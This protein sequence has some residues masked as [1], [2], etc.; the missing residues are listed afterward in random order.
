MAEN[1]SNSSTENKAPAK[2]NI[3]VTS[4]WSEKDV[5]KWNKEEGVTLFFDPNS[6]VELSSEAANELSYYSAQSYFQA[7][8]AWKDKK[9]RE[10]AEKADTF[11]DLKVRDPLSASTANEMKLRERRGYHQTWKRPDEIESAKRV[12]YSDIRKQKKG[13]DKK[14]GYE[15]G[16]VITIQDRN[17]EEELRAME[18][19][20][21]MYQQHLKVVS[22]RVKY[23][24][25][26]NVDRLEETADKASYE[27]GDKNAVKIKDFS[28]DDDTKWRDVE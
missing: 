2:R 18:V 8:H 17:G 28:E 21:D 9:R 4:D 20:V 6:F 19:P 10:E 3:P 7:L 24:K 15:R 25:G 26:Q 14:P 13:E 11:E 16:E 22:D 23:R 12:G 27:L 5:L 1:K